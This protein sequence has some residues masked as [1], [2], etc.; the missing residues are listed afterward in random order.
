MSDEKV[1]ITYDDRSKGYIE[2][3]NLMV[4]DECG[5][6][7]VRGKEMFEGGG[8]VCINPDCNYWFCY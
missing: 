8:V 5:K 4:C 3:K 1:L 2:K 7:T 6:Q